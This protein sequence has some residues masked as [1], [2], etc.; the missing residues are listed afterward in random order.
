MRAWIGRRPFFIAGL[1]AC[2]LVLLAIIVWDGSANG[3]YVAARLLLPF[4]CVAIGEYSAAA[5]IASI[6]AVIEWPVYGAVIDTA[7]RKLWSIGAILFI[8]F[9]LTLWLFTGG[10]SAFS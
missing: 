1:L 2:P 4:A 8:H 10:R 6:L 9:G 3:N 5:W 7:G